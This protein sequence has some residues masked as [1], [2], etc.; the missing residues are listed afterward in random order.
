MTAG[1][2]RNADTALPS[3]PVSSALP[4]QSGMDRGRGHAATATSD[5]SRHRELLA[6]REITQAFLT[7]ERP[8]DVYSVA[9]ER[10][11]PL[12]GAAF[13]CVYL[14]QDADDLMRLAAAHNWPERYGRFL[15]DMR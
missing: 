14:L 1:A 11:T 10:V 5:D 12:V 9:L 6:M 15:G 7:A 2:P 3:I 8:D 13:A 4:F